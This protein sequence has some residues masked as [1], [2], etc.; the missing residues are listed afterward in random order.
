MGIIQA[1]ADVIV[2]CRG[3]ES[4]QI[5]WK[6]EARRT[7][8]Q[9]G[10]RWRATS[11][12]CRATGWG[13]VRSWFR[14]A[15]ARS[16]IPHL[17]LGVRFLGRG[18]GCRPAG[19]GGAGGPTRGPDA[20]ST[21]PERDRWPSSPGLGG[22]GRVRAEFRRKARVPRLARI[23]RVPLRAAMAAAGVVSFLAIGMMQL[24]LTGSS[25]PSGGN[26]FAF[27]S[28]GLAVVLPPLLAGDA[29]RA[30]RHRISGSGSSRF[31]GPPRTSDTTGA[32]E[33]PRRRDPSR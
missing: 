10:R 21:S 33:S 6:C 2:R 31:G 26:S 17:G 9:G 23:P 16:P 13:R 19:H 18:L 3:K 24:G 15:V 28:S 1:R 29:D 20:T 30:P 22:A 32:S 27:R 5:E 12:G 4:L 11:S 25:R 8:K 7:T 14:S